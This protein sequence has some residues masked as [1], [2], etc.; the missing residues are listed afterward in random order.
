MIRVGP[1]VKITAEVLTKRGAPDAQACRSPMRLQDHENVWEFQRRGHGPGGE[2]RM[3][4]GV[5]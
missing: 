3:G 1:L 5:R 2:A 4:M